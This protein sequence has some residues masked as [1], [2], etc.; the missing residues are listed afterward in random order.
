MYITNKKNYPKIMVDTIKQSLDRYSRGDA[1]ISVTELIGSP[2]A[3]ILKAKHGHELEVDVDALYFMFYG[4]VAHK[5]ME[6]LVSDSILYKEHRMF[7]EV[8]GKKI[9][10]ALDIVYKESGKLRLD[11]VKFTAKSVADKPIKKAWE[12]Q[13]NLY[14]Y[15]LYRTENVKVNEL[16]IIALYRN[17]TMYDSKCARLPVKMFTIERMEEYL[18]KQIAFH[19]LCESELIAQIPECTPEDRWHEPEKYAVMPKPGAKK[20]LKN[21]DTREMAEQRVDREK[22]KHPEVFLEVRSAKNKRCEEA[23]PMN[24]F[25][26]W[27]QDIKLGFI[28]D[29]YTGSEPERRKII[30]D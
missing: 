11:D 27:Y 29:S 19:K 6:C 5:V 26:W 10:G 15:M 22:A 21:Y 13:A 1:D 28:T 4:N 9:S 7:L 24:K 18:E 30:E 25:C 2:L 14:R 8:K 16:G 17:S 20:S 23:C 12:R 3:R